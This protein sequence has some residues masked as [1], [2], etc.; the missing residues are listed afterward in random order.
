MAHASRGFRRCGSAIGAMVVGFGSSA[1]VQFALFENRFGDDVTFRS[2]IAEIQD[3]AALAAKREFGMRRRIC[4]LT[5]NGA[6]TFH[7][8][9]RTSANKSDV[10]RRSSGYQANT[11]SGVPVKIF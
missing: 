1:L 4:G 3:P 6:T 2:P 8:P 5:A 10:P 9:A 7:Q 11:R